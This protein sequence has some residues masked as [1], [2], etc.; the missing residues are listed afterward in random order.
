MKRIF[1]AVG[2]TASNAVIELARRCRDENLDAPGKLAQ[3]FKF[4]TIDTVPNTKANLEALYEDS[5][6][7]HGIYLTSE[8]PDSPVLDSLLAVRGDWRGPE[9]MFGAYGAYGWRYK[10]ALTRTW[11]GELK[12]YFDEWKEEGIEVLV[13]GTACGATCTGMY[14]DVAGCLRSWSLPNSGPPK[15]M[16][17]GVVCLP[18]VNKSVK[19]NYGYYP[20]VKNF[21]AFMQDMRQIAILNSLRR[22]RNKE[23]S[24]GGR[25][26]Y[27]RPVSFAEVDKNGTHWE[28]SVFSLKALLSGE[29]TSKL[30][31]DAMFFLPAQEDATEIANH[32]F[33]YSAIYDYTGDGG[34]QDMGNAA[35]EGGVFGGLDLAVATSPLFNAVKKTVQEK[36]QDIRNYFL[37]S[38]DKM[39][40]KDREKIAALIRP[41]S[42]SLPE[43]FAKYLNEPR[44]WFDNWVKSVLEG[45][46][47]AHRLELIQARLQERIDEGGR[48]WKKPFPL[49]FFGGDGFMKKIKDDREAWECVARETGIKGTIQGLKD[50]YVQ[51][52]DEIRSIGGSTQQELDRKTADMRKAMEKARVTFETSVVSRKNR[53]AVKALNQGKEVQSEAATSFTAFAK[54]WLN[55]QEVVYLMHYLARRLPENARLDREVGKYSDY[56]TTATSEVVEVKEAPGQQLEQRVIVTR[57]DVLSNLVAGMEDFNELTSEETIQKGYRDT[58]DRFVSQHV[59]QMLDALDKDPTFD[60]SRFMPRFENQIS[61]FSSVFRREEAAGM[62]ENEMRVKHICK[63][64]GKVVKPTYESV[65]EFS[66]SFKS[67]KPNG[68]S[69]PNRTDSFD[70]FAGR[71]QEAN[72]ITREDVDHKTSCYFGQLEGVPTTFMGMWLGVLALDKSLPALLADIFDA[73]KLKEIED[74]SMENEIRRPGGVFRRLINLKEAVELGVVLGY[75]TEKIREHVD[76]LRKERPHEEGRIGGVHL[77]RKD[78]KNELVTWNNTQINS[79]GDGNPVKN[80]GGIDARTLKNVL[81]WLRELNERPESVERLRFWFDQDW[82]PLTS[83]T[84]VFDENNPKFL[85]AL[86]DLEEYIGSQLEVQFDAFR[87]I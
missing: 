10:S 45:K 38:T 12:Q 71:K 28:D 61:G 30:P 68:G 63:H 69:E 27:F 34:Q 19:T 84:F 22:Q 53:M 21:C 64:A 73:Q 44:E 46:T 7:V 5:S 81:Q 76:S 57:K 32:L 41:Q 11:V 47:P 6:R 49:T 58:Y 42:D 66:P 59:T 56:V 16:V 75:L 2:S 35:Q 62:G 9:Y 87:G 86:S 36:W 29:G 8:K 13:V 17:C 24:P 74:D 60:K 26:K 31:L 80:T 20:I 78:N 50:V 77:L 23:S 67:I 83:E 70:P 14:W 15:T 37:S 39:D 4:I 3:D 79:F 1:V 54:E 85:N 40:S 25:I 72:Q 52:C 51:V 33:V 48:D 43:V 18:D 65:W 55:R 82:M